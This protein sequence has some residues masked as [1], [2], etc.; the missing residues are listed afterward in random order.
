MSIVT[1]YWG[2]PPD[3]PGLQIHG[4]H[5]WL[6][7]HTCPNGSSPLGT[8][9]YSTVNVGD[10]AWRSWNGIQVHDGLTPTEGVL[11]EE[12]FG[13]PIETPVPLTARAA[14]WVL[15][16]W[17]PVLFMVVVVVGSAW[18]FKRRRQG[19]PNNRVAEADLFE[20]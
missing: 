17:Q 7:G 4:D 9:G 6:G 5:S 10:R 14:A 13:P 1:R 20:G 19:R 8:L 2:Q 16:L 3:K 11:L 15:L 18:L 12:R